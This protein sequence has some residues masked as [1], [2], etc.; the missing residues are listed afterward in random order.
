VEVRKIREFATPLG[1]LI[2]PNF[3]TTPPHLYILITPLSNSS[4]GGVECYLYFRVLFLLDI[5]L[6]VTSHFH[7]LVAFFPTCFKL[8]GAVVLSALT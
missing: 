7:S 1:E 2:P 6:H 4:Q 5:T 3:P 8:N